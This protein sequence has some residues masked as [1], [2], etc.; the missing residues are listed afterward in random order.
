ML[1]KNV[2]KNLKKPCE[3]YCNYIF[4]EQYNCLHSSIILLTDTTKGDGSTVKC[5]ECEAAAVGNVSLL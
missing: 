5:F 1:C 4:S 2:I 3:V